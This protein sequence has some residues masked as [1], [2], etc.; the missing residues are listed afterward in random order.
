MTLMICPGSGTLAPASCDVIFGAMAAWG[1][2][3]MKIN[4]Q[5]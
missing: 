3:S 4:A 5:R 1:K 2:L